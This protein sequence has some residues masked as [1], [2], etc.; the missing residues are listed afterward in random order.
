MQ[1]LWEIAM[2]RALRHCLAELEEAIAI[3]IL[4][5]LPSRHSRK[6]EEQPKQGEAA[7][8][9]G[10]SKGAGEE[11]MFAFVICVIFPT[12]KANVK[13]TCKHR[14]SMIL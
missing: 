6:D 1:G 9:E 7:F 11:G 4:S 10:V 5:W 8:K 14:F 2:Q 3:M 13:G 12:N